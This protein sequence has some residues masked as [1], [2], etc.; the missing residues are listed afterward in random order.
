MHDTIEKAKPVMIRKPAVITEGNGDILK[1]QKTVDEFIS[2][3][4]VK[5]IYYS[6]SMIPIERKAT[7]IQGVGRGINLQMQMIPVCYIIFEE[8]FF[9]DEPIKLHTT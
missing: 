6:M 8:E 2:K 5:E 3:H 1:F 9:L 4:A 7:V